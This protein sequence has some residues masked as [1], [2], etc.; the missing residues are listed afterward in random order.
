M[1][2]QEAFGSSSCPTIVMRER[3]SVSNG[4]DDDYRTRELS[5]QFHETALRKEGFD[6]GFATALGI[7]ALLVLGLEQWTLLALGMLVGAVLISANAWAEGVLIAL[8]GWFVNAW[9]VGQRVRHGDASSP[10]WIE[11]LTDPMSLSVFAMITTVWTIY[12]AVRYWRARSR[13][14]A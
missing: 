6:K 1:L 12:F 4:G 7:I 5:R 11:S 2:A 3:L 10:F 13:T 8:T 14:V 9:M